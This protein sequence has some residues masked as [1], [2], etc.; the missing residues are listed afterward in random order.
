MRGIKDIY[1]NRDLAG[2]SA[3]SHMHRCELNVEVDMK[4]FVRMFSAVVCPRIGPR[5]GPHI[6]RLETR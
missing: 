2:K 6:H 3:G 1:L 5:G 4:Y